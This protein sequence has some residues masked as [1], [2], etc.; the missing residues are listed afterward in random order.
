MVETMWHVA[1]ATAISFACGWAAGLVVVDV[2]FAVVL[3]AE[4]F[5]VVEVGGAAAGPVPDVVCFTEAGGP[6]ALGVL[7][8]PVADDERAPE[9]VGDVA[10]GAADVDDLGLGPSVM[11]R[12]ISQSHDSRSRVVRERCP[13]CSASARM[14]ATRSGW[15]VS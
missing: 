9:L 14:S 15:S 13:T 10:G 7:A 4:E 3:P 12:L 6:G 2:D 11:I 8:V 1:E 5:Q